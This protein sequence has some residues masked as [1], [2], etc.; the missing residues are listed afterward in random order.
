MNDDARSWKIIP[1]RGW[2]P[3]DLGMTRNE[4]LHALR[5]AK[6]EFD[7]VDNEDPSFLDC[8]SP[9]GDFEFEG[10]GNRLSQ[11]NVYE[12]PLSFDCPLNSPT[13]DTVLSELGVRSFTDTRWACSQLS[14]PISEDADKTLLRLGVLWLPSHGLGLE[15]D[16]GEVGAVYIRR[17]NDAPESD[18]GPLTPRQLEIV[19]TP[20]LREA[21]RPAHVAVQRPLGPPSLTYLWVS[22]CVHLCFVAFLLWQGYRAYQAEMRWKGAMP[23]EGE[24]IKTLPEGNAFPDAY[25][26]RY[27]PPASAPQQIKLESQFVGGLKQAG[28]KVEIRYLP[29]QPEQATTIW[30]AR[31]H[32]SLDYLLTAIYCSAAYFVILVALNFLR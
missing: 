18:L 2:G 15:M 28:E 8:N 11:I 23:I 1:G 31:D 5:K 19:A 32:P 6:A 17:G 26:I 24:I 20:E 21:L 16:N 12:A 7:E 30:E 9:W 25:L 22:R 10:E 29:H 3:I 27:L 14:Q 13:L 4:V